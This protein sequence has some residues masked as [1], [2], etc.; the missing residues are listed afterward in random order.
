MLRNKPVISLDYAVNPQSRYGYGKP[1]HPQLHSIIN[2]GHHRY[3]KELS[4]LLR[5]KQSL[6]N[7]STPLWHNDFLPA[8]DAA[9]LYSFTAQ[10]KPNQYFEVGSGTSTR[11]VRQAI[12]DQSLPAKITSIDPQPRADI[13]QLCHHVIRQALEK[14]NLTIFNQLDKN[15]ILF[16]DN[17]HQSFQN[18]DVTVFFLDILP[19]LKPGV[20][21]GIHDIL[22]PD[23][24]PPSYAQN[25]YSEQYLLACW[26]LGGA[27]N[28]NIVLPNWFCSQDLELSSIIKTLFSHPNF[29]SVDTHGSI[30]W[31][32]KT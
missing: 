20:L 25:Y 31:F 30:F 27:K 24:Y 26:L 3:L 17:S 22:L 16:I 7:I 4:K 9:T 2:A 19:N 28:I 6:H 13:D 5:H 29:Q 23:D 10:L 21:V 15:D 8:L 12:N 14:T 11:F 32:R 1:P 18:S